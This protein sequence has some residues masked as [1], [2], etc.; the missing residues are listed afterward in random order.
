[1]GNF[2]TDISNYICS[3]HALLN[4]DTF[5][6]D[7]AISEIAEAAKDIDRKIYIWSIAQG[8]IDEKG[9]QVC[10]VKNTAPVE[11]HLQAVLQFDEGV[12]CILRDFGSYLQHQT[13]P[14]YDVVIGWL[15][16]L[17]KIVASVRQTIIFVGPDF[18]IPKQLLHDITQID[19]SL[20]D[21]EQV[22]ERIKFVCSDVTKADGTKFKPNKKIIPQVIDACRG[23][24]CQQTVDRVALALRKHKDLNPD[25]IQTIV[26]EK[27]G[28]IRSSGL[29]EYIEPPEGG[30]ANVGGYDALKQHVRLDKPC[31]T[32]E[33]REFGIEFPRGLM[34]VGIPGCGKTLLSLA[35]ASELGLPLI[36]MDVGNLMDKFVGESESNMREAIQ[37]LES[38]APAV[39]VLDE[40]E[41][42]FA[43]AGDMD[44]GASRR[45]F[46]TFIKWL[47]DRRSPV[48]VVATANQVQSLP[49]EFCRKGRFDEIY[50]L[51]LPNLKERQEIFCIHISKRNRKPS[52]FE[53]EKLSKISEG[54][55]GSDI[56]QIIRLGLKMAFADNQQLKQEYLEKAVSEIIPLS[57]SE[58]DRI[59]EIRKWCAGHSKL[60]NPQK[61]IS[62]PKIGVRKVDLN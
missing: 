33:A 59:A 12:I 46:G 41:K 38:I 11:D 62:P 8:W 36:A 30:L 50:G 27:A 40:I 22:G 17:R 60:A 29:L 3:G 57:Q 10:K 21:N 55:T 9:T 14:N 15:D 28:V 31:F 25:A 23:M 49:P 54:Y 6:K 58:G 61:K 34:L 19:F 16:E 18:H 52:N 4:V 26:R 7:R 53:V 35:I 47:N 51:D 39:L 5:E 43:G 13:Y 24:T 56:E 37:M 32:K 2:L 1:M 44:G 48:Y 42:G 45:V 20:P